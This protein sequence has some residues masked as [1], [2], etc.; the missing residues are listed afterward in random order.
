MRPLAT[1]IEGQ[2]EKEG[3]VIWG[4]KRGIPAPLIESFLVPGKKIVFKQLDRDRKLGWLP[5]VR[6]PSGRAAAFLWDLQTNHNEIAGAD[7]NSMQTC[8]QRVRKVFFRE[9]D[10]R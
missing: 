10:Q 9:R 2:T 6:C 8:P 3:V 1:E 4:E 7:V 5:K